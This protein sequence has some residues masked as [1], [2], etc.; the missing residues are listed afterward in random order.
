MA[1]LKLVWPPTVLVLELAEA[2]LARVLIVCSEGLIDLWVFFSD[3][4]IKRK[5]YFQTQTLG[6]CE[7]AFVNFVLAPLEVPQDGQHVVV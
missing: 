7:P 3:A 1:A 6:I 4:H 2:N 5:T